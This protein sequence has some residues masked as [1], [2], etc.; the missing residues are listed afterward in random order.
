MNPS[1]HSTCLR[2]YR[3]Y[4]GQI[5]LLHTFRCDFLK[6]IDV[7][8]F[9]PACSLKILGCTFFDNTFFNTQSYCMLSEKCEANRRRQLLLPRQAVGLGA[10]QTIVRRPLP[11]PHLTGT[12]TRYT[13]GFLFGSVP[14]PCGE[15]FWSY[16]LY[17]RKFHTGILACVADN[18]FI[19][20]SHRSRR[21]FRFI[22]HFSKLFFWKFFFSFTMVI[23]RPRE[24]RGESA[25]FGNRS[26]SS[27]SK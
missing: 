24:L 10:P 18:I 25:A 8:I 15:H 21:T 14:P 5:G 12:I 23:K 7:L 26:A 11:S 13:Q 1:R 9:R 27:M 17:V 19:Y 20:F 3:A 6:K 4:S 2:S 22:F 16:R